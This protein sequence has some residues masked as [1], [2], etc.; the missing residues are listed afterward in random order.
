MYILYSETEVISSTSWILNEMEEKDEDIFDFW[1]KLLL[2]L[3]NTANK[4]NIWV[5]S[6]FVSDQEVKPQR[7]FF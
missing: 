2:H 6:V 1:L 7:F 4:T 5:K 3:Q